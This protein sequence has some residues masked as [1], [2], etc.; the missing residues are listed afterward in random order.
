[1]NVAPLYRTAPISPIVQA[2][3]LNTVVLADLPPGDADDPFRILDR[4]KSLERLAGREG[5]ERFGPRPLD[6]DLLL[7]GDLVRGPDAPAPEGRNPRDL[8]LPH[9]RMRARRFVLAP[10]A[11][12]APD[13]ELPPDNAVVRDLLAALGP[14]QR[15]EKIGWGS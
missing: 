9:P 1:M 12:L 3:F 5:G 11:D 13:L 8:I 4:V 7:V 14:E 10:L 2:D 15:V 6:V